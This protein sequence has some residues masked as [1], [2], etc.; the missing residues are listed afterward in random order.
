[1]RATALLELRNLRSRSLP[2]L[3]MRASSDPSPIVRRSV[4]LAARELPA[5]LRPEVVIALLDD[6]LRTVRIEAVS[7]LLRS[8]TRDWKPADREAFDRATA[9]YEEARA[10]NADRAEGL[11][12]L[13]HLA[14]VKRTPEKA[15]AILREAI[16]IDPTF[17]A[18]HVNLADLYRAMGRD[19]DAET[20]LRDALESTA[21][22]ATVEHALGLALIRLDRHAEAQK[23][24]ARAY[25]LRPESIRFGYVYAVSQFDRG[26]RDAAVRTLDE[27]H[28]RY[29]ANLEVL[30]LLLNYNRQLGRKDAAARYST[31]LQELGVTP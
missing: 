19:R 18:G 14:T 8:N 12:D 25:E 23:H 9:E 21:D 24:L 30:M 27:I 10:F 5:N 3:L 1:M 22:R 26:R 29:P 7:T 15:E 4:A 31:E 13:A 11:V 20:V 28:A 17:T 6:P 16:D 2:A